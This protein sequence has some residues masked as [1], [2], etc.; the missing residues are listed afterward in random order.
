MR[1]LMTRREIKIFKKELLKQ[2]ENDDVLEVLEWGSGGSTY[3]FT[4]FLRDNNINYTW[5]SLEYNAL[6]YQKVSESL[7]GDKH[8]NLVLFDVGNNNLK[9]RNISMDEYVNYPETLHKKFNIIFIDGRKR[10]RCVLKSKNLLKQNGVVFLHDAQRK[11]YQCAFSEFK[12]HSFV[13]PY[14]WRGV[15]SDLGKF[16]L[17]KNKF[18]HF[19]WKS[20]YFLFSKPYHFCLNILRSIYHGCR[21]K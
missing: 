10:R 17:I 7:S 16:S 13:D 6:W 9:Q 5:T 3:F 20:F 18:R 15:N 8:T 4:N 19:F 11:Y 12:N 1:P 2:A 14:M 21:K